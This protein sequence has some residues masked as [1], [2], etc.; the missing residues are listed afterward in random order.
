M[1]IEVKGHS[2]CEINVVR[3]NDTLF[4]YKSSP[5][6]NAK[7]AARLL[8]QA[9]KQ[10]EAS[11]V[12][13]RNIRVP[14]VFQ[15]IDKGDSATIKMPYVYS[16]S[17]VEYFE[18]SGFEQINYFIKAIEYFIDKEVEASPIIKV[19]NKVFVDKLAE[20]RCNT[21][22][23]PEMAADVEILSILNRA[24]GIVDGM[25]DWEIPIGKCH[26]DLTFSNIL[27]NGNNY[28]LIDFLDSYVETPLQDIVKIRQDTAYLWSQLMYM[29]SYDEVRL[30][31]I[32]DKMDSEIDAYFSQRYTWYKEYYKPLQLM[33]LLRILPYAH[34]QRVVDYLKTIITGLLN[35][36]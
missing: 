3:E 29:Q 22:A 30:R 1:E 27:F 36:I 33:N 35:E 10:R 20:V 25:S 9:E 7:Y 2:G 18:S 34:E 8:K 23:K 32:C 15:I 6:H 31:I 5:S 17:F 24:Q 16:K 11:S 26:G 28:F 13:Y 4:V 12:E 14:E 21:L 19:A